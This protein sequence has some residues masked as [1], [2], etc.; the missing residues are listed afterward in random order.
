MKIVI[1]NTEFPY[2]LGCRLLKLKNEVCPFKELKGEWNNIKPLT[3]KEIA[4]MENLEQRRVGILCLGIERLIKEVKPKL[5][6]K[7]TIKKTT[8]YI[9]KEGKVVVSKFNDTYELFEVEGAYFSQGLQSHQ[10]MENCHFVKCKD[11][12]TKREYLIWV[13]IKRVSETNGGSR[14]HVD[15]KTINAIQCIAWT[16]QTTVAE[17]NIEKIL[18]Q[19]DCVLVKPKDMKEKMLETPRH[20]TEKEYKKLLVAES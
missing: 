12:S 9:D 11:T 3:F 8:T 5:I 6:D 13:D 7:Q 4:K 19:G 2:D 14:W 1:E 10:K 17:G 20:L 15:I 18:R 16:I